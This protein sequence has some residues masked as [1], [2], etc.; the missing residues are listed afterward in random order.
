[1]THYCEPEVFDYGDLR[2][3]TSDCFGGQGGDSRVPGGE[4]AG[5]SFGSDTSTC[6]SA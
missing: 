6:Q 4:L 3:L 2:A 1:M 5:Y